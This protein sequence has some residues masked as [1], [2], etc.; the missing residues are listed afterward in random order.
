M[1]ITAV[2]KNYEK[3]T[4]TSGKIIIAVCASYVYVYGKYASRQQ[5]GLLPS[6]FSCLWQGR[7]CDHW[8]NM[9]K[10]KIVTTGQY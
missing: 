9:V 4:E 3:N 5:G 8:T 7:N 1:Q 2:E 10:Q 6:V